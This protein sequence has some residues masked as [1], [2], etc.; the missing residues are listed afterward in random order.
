MTKLPVQKTNTQNNTKAR[1]TQDAT[2]SKNTLFF[3]IPISL[4][5]IY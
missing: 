5:K 3:G 1:R 4:F 2:D